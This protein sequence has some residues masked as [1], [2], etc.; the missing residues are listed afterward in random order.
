LVLE[1]WLFGPQGQFGPTGDIDYDWVTTSGSNLNVKIPKDG[2]LCFAQMFDATSNAVPLRHK[3]ASLGKHFFDLKYPAAEQPWDAIKDTLRMKPAR[4]TGP[5]GPSLGL[6]PQMM[7][8]YVLAREVG[9]HRS[10]SHIEDMFELKKPGLYTVRLQFQAY[11]Q[12]Y[13]GGHKYAYKLHRFDP[14]EFAVKKGQ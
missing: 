10:F 4:I 11:E 1:I 5:T 13:K 6:G 12:I 3:F 9:E 8:D 14:V 7:A 2:Y